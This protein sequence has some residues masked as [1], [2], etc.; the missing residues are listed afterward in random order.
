MYIIK[1]MSKTEVKI[2]EEEYK[3][4]LAS[5]AS[6]RIF[7]ESLKGTINLNSVESIL[8]EDLVKKEITEGYL[9]DGT[10]VIK[11]FGSW[12][13]ASNPEIK[14]DYNYYPELATDEV[15]LK[16]EYAEYKKVFWELLENKTQTILDC[17][18]CN[19]T[20]I[21]D[22]FDGQYTYTP[23]SKRCSCLKNEIKNLLN[24]DIVKQ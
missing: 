15:M 17:K 14:L 5:K 2:T 23:T 3:R 24:K 10:K 6:G 21:L 4:I 18:I 8:P 7:I 1:M 12:K 19:G 16:E 20:T 9:H 22:Y 11:Q 13:D